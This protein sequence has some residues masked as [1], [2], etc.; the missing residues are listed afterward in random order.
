[1]K[2]LKIQFLV[3]NKDSWIIEP[4]SKYIKLLK[5]NYNVKFINNHNQIEKNNFLFILSSLKK[6]S[7]KHLRL[8]NY[9]LVV[10]PSKL[11]MG[12]GFSPLEWDVLKGKNIIWFTLF[13]ANEN[14]DSGNFYIQKKITLNG[15]E[16]RDD[17]KKLQSKIIFDLCSQFLKKYKRLSSIDQKG[18]SY[19]YPK[20]TPQDSQLNINKSI[21]EQINLL[22]IVDNKNY[23]AFFFYKKK[24]I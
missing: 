18:K 2:K 4:L 6:V 22:R 21:K 12:K 1:M 10:H 9:N 23:P 8:S 5:V 19:Y 14:F 20:R 7:I 11:P 16:L 13:E 24:N 3:D 15:T 17:L